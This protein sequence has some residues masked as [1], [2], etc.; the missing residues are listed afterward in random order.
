MGC[1]QSVNQGSS[2]SPAQNPPTPSQ[3]KN[4]EPRSSSGSLRAD[5]PR[6]KPSSQEKERSRSRAG[7]AGS[8]NSPKNGDQNLNQNLNQNQFSTQPTSRNRS[9]SHPKQLDDTS[10]TL[11]PIQEPKRRSV[12][13]R[14][15]QLES[16]CGLEPIILTTTYFKKDSKLQG[17]YT[18]KGIIG[19][20]ATAKVY[21]Y[22]DNETGTQYAVKKFNKLLLKKSK[23]Y[24]NDPITGRLVTKT[25]FD[26]VLNEIEILKYIH[27]PAHPVNLSHICRV[28]EI[29]DDPKSDKLFM[30]MEYGSLGTAAEWDDQSYSFLSN[31]LKTES[32][33][34]MIFLQMLVALNS[35]RQIGVIHRDIKPTNIIITPNSAKLIDFGDAILLPKKYPTVQAQIDELNRYTDEKSLSKNGSRGDSISINGVISVNGSL[36]GD[37]GKK[38]TFD[39]IN[40]PPLASPTLTLPQSH[41]NTPRLAKGNGGELGES[42]YEPGQDQK[43]KVVVIDD[44]LTGEHP[45]PRQQR[46]RS[47]SQ[48]RSLSRV[49][50]EA[51]FSPATNVID[52]NNLFSSDV[53]D[54]TSQHS[55]HID[56][57]GRITIPFTNDM[58]ADRDDNKSDWIPKNGAKNEEKVY[59]NPDEIVVTKNNVKNIWYQL[60]ILNETPATP[61]FGSPESC[62]GSYNGFDND[63]WALSV[64]FF[65]CVTGQLPFFSLQNNPDATMMAS[66]ELIQKASI[67]WPVEKN[68]KATSK[69]FV[70]LMSWLLS[71]NPLDRPTIEMCQSH[72]YLTQI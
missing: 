37:V 42:N 10:P 55:G 66:F 33:A 20:G 15:D 12:F 9:R 35:L 53:E 14:H 18:K 36:D 16:S 41:S 61:Y 46:R 48:S 19:E 17:R 44:A 30:I 8:P 51:S 69:D 52:L 43:N 49:N 31:S 59:V 13:N 27:N 4:T 2:N 47:V 7:S 32:Q 57:N 26:K 11:T 40:L 71:K 3:E 21:E 45:T 62:E 24:I 50:P 60:A 63:L 38:P 5:G 65:C 68:S 34:S 70:Q 39:L 67:K 1:T 72:P 56:S 54:I 22:V 64:S 23:N 28:Y 58:S 6:L 29:I 25:R